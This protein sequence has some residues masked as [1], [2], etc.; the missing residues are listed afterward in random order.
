[1]GNG[2]LAI[3]CYGPKEIWR[4]VKGPLLESAVT[5]ARVT[6]RMG[7]YEETMELNGE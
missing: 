6:M 4:V 1:V 3:Y 5:E 7:G 2:T